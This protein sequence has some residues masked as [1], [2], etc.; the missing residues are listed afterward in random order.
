MVFASQSIFALITQK[1]GS[2]YSFT[3]ALTNFRY[4]GLS[5]LR[6]WMWSEYHRSVNPQ[7]LI[8]FNQFNGTGAEP[9]FY[10]PAWRNMKNWTW[11]ECLLLLIIRSTS[12]SWWGSSWRSTSQRNHGNVFIFHLEIFNT[13]TNEPMV[14]ATIFR[15]HLPHSCSETLL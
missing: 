4:E 15:P 9:A 5:I 11:F 2:F 10:R 1:S 6:P 13:F 7:C 3:P 8:S 12:Y 14:K